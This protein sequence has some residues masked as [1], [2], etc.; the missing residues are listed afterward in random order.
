[1]SEKTLA[2]EG[3]N[4][5]FRKLSDPVVAIIVHNKCLHVI[6]EISLIYCCRQNFENPQK[7]DM[8]VNLA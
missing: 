3:K 5:S 6:I 2:W 7:N 1:M 8:E 4:P